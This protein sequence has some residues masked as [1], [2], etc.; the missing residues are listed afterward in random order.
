M[1]FLF[2]RW[3]RCNVA[4]VFVDA[5]GSGFGCFVENVT[6]S[7]VVGSW[8][9]PELR[10]SFTWR[11]LKAVR[12]SIFTHTESLQGK[13][14]II[15]SD[16]KNVCNIL[17]VGSGK[18]DLHKK[19]LSL[20]EHCEKFDI[21]LSPEWIPRNENKQADFL[22]RSYDCNDWSTADDI[23]REPDIK[24]GPHTYDC[25]AYDYNAKHRNF[26]SRFW[27]PGTSGVGAFVK[28]WAGENNWLVPPPRLISRCV[29]NILKDKCD[30]TLI[31]P[32]WKSAPFWPVLFPNAITPA[33]FVSQYVRYEPGVLTKRGRGKNGIFD[34]RH[35]SFSLTAIR[36]VF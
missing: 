36:I 13:S 32:V 34:G 31:I 4:N 25:F 1:W 18:A 19:A 29:R 2:E 28:Q 8:S 3:H 35:L 24:W 10:L 21:I 12:R 20:V 15:K 26:N 23:S 22:S 5:S 16:N 30:C 7:E 27:C 33:N 9:E 6:D 17:N 14:V 11:E